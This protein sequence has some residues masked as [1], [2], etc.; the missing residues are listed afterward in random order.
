MTGSG[1]GGEALRDA[2]TSAL[3]QL[4]PVCVDLVGPQQPDTGKSPGN[5][6]DGEQTQGT[7]LRGLQILQWR[8]EEGQG[9]PFYTVHPERPLE[10]Q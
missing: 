4:C 3:D 7:L 1:Q 2:H 6:P 8:K 5:G 10:E 9:S